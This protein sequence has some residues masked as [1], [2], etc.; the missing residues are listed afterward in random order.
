VTDWHDYTDESEIIGLIP[1]EIEIEFKEGKKKIPL[2]ID[3]ALFVAHLPVVVPVSYCKLKDYDGAE[4]TFSCMNLGL[5]IGNAV[6]KP[7]SIGVFSLMESTNNP[8][9]V[10]FTKTSTIQQF[11]ALYFN[12]FREHAAEL[13]RDWAYEEPPEFDPENEE[14]WTELDKASMVYVDHLGMQGVDLTSVETWEKILQLFGTSSNG[15]EMVPGS[16]GSRY[17]FGGETIGAMVAGMGAELNV[18]AH[19]VMW[20]TPLALIGF[21]QAAKAKENGVKGVCRPRDRADMRR[22]RILAYLR[23]LHGELHQWQIDKPLGHVLTP[24]Q[25]KHRSAVRQFEKLQAQAKKDAK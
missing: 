21:M 23:E 25:A 20:N 2:K 16:G 13:A 12:E 3:G 17:W 14:T 24:T 1:D 15:F 6:I 10:D 19:D 18:S 4:E 5:R 8:F 22:Q 11:H 7:P 9:P